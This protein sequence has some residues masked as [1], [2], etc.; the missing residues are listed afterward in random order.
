MLLLKVP[1]HAEDCCSVQTTPQFCFLV[2]VSLFSFGF[3]LLYLMLA[4]WLL[5]CCQLWNIH[6]PII[7]SSLNYFQVVCKELRNSQYLWRYHCIR[8]L[9][10][11]GK[12]FVHT[13]IQLTKGGV[14]AAWWWWG[15]KWKSTWSD[16]LHYMDLYCC[17]YW[18]TLHDMVWLSLLWYYSFKCTFCCRIMFCPW[19]DLSMDF[20]WS[21][22]VTGLQ[23]HDNWLQAPCDG[24]TQWVCS[25]FTLSASLLCSYWYIK[26]WLVADSML[27]WLTFSALHLAS[28]ELED[29]AEAVDFNG[30]ISTVDFTLL[31]VF[32]P[33]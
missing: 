31:S 12:G 17:W 7:W 3:S 29:Y 2:L 25:L 20:N 26:W 9:F 14:W 16:S 21:Q 4:G 10:M 28:V 18:W 33:G 22:W 6:N 32:L 24:P 8:Y 19:N 13:A 27:Y 11:E 23:V 5:L 30:N 1:G 15:G